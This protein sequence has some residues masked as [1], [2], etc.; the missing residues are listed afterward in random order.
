MGLEDTYPLPKPQ[1]KSQC[2]P[3]A[4]KYNEA[5]EQIS[6]KEQEKIKGSPNEGEEGKDEDSTYPLPKKTGQMF[7]IIQKHVPDVCLYRSEGLFCFLHTE[8]EKYP[9]PKPACTN[10]VS[11][12]GNFVIAEVSEQQ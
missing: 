5:R 7:V 12:V 8:D 11:K 10:Q 3:D 6:V 1:K 2:I 9:R 4:C